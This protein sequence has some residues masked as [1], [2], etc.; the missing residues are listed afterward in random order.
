MKYNIVIDNMTRAVTSGSL[1]DVVEHI[2]YTV[3]VTASKDDNIY[4]F[5]KNPSIELSK[6]VSPDDF[7]EYGSLTEGT[8]KSWITGS[9]D[10]DAILNK[11]E[12]NV[13]YS[14]WPENYPPSHK[15]GLPW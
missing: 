10:W 4:H 14:L 5:E 6:P 1:S 11:S 8:I 12:M 7:I 3:W 13:S 15:S 9:T 2:D